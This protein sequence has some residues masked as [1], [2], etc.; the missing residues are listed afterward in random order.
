MKNI[1][2]SLA[3]FFYNE[4]IKLEELKDKLYH[5]ILKD[6]NKQLKDGDKNYS[7]QIDNHFKNFLIELQPQC[8]G[9]F[10]QSFA[11]T[12]K[13]EQDQWVLLYYKDNK[14]DKLRDDLRYLV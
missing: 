4:D 9:I 11:F 8:S 10:N 6:F 2:K 1:E 12:Q 14:I 13:L 3:Q 5:D 7:H